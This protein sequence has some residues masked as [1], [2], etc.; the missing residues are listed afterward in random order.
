MRVP[1]LLLRLCVRTRQLLVKKGE[2]RVVNAKLPR[3]CGE[4]GRPRRRRQ[5]G[6]R[7]CARPR[8]LLLHPLRSAHHD[9]RQVELAREAAKDDGDVHVHARPLSF[10]FTRASA[11]CGCRRRLHWQL[12]L[13]ARHRG[14]AARRALVAET[15]GENDAI[16]ACELKLRHRRRTPLPGDHRLTLRRAA[17]TP[18]PLLRHSPRVTQVLL[19]LPLSSERVCLRAHG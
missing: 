19:S 16:R 14:D 6:R 1:S 3:R 15:R 10:T 4:R 12:V 11:R 17:F 5:R 18:Q 2:R 13:P 7:G 9:K 8:N